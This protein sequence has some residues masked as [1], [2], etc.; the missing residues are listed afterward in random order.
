MIRVQTIVLFCFAINWPCGAANIEVLQLNGEPAAAIVVTVT[1]TSVSLPPTTLNTKESAPSTIVSQTNKKFSPYLSVVQVGAEVIFEN[2]DNIT[3]HIYS[4]NSDE[5][6]DFKLKQNQQN[7]HLTFK[8]AKSIAMG[9]NIHD[10][11]AGHILVVDTPYFALTNEQGYV[12][13]ENI[14]AGEYALSI[15]HPQLHDEDAKFSKTVQWPLQ[16]PI[17]ISLKHPMLTK[18][19][20]QSMDEFDFLEGY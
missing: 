3:H 2:Q 11:M 7:K 12:Q 15:Y 5:R 17:Q 8:T 6:F 19:Q 14:P 18:P 20:Q 16:K 1:S 13:F 10:W 9:C 4:L